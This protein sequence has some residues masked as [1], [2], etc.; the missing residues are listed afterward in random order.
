MGR[1]ST[2]NEQLSLFSVPCYPCPCVP[3]HQ[4]ISTACGLPQTTPLRGIPRP[5][6]SRLRFPSEEYCHKDGTRG[7]GSGGRICSSSDSGD[8]CV[9][10]CVEQVWVGRDL[11]RWSLIFLL[12][13]ILVR[14]AVHGIGVGCRRRSGVAHS[15]GEMRYVWK[16]RREP[17]LRPWW[18]ERI[19]INQV[20]VVFDTGR[21]SAT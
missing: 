8:T 11:G 20:P 2:R 13:I 17:W 1:T 5:L 16:R 10:S 14:C 12:H 7:L 15:Q 9:F 19:Q 6:T 21:S 3:G 18:L 4:G